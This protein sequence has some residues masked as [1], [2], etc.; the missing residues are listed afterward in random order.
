MSLWNILGPFGTF[1]GPSE[2]WWQFDGHLIITTSTISIPSKIYPNR[3]FCLK[4]YDL[5][6]LIPIPEKLEP[7]RK[8]L[9]RPTAWQESGNFSRTVFNRVARWFVFKPKISIWVN[10]GGP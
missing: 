5:A 10:F 6:P 9:R 2:I 3:D 1:Y 8:C 4:I 7:F